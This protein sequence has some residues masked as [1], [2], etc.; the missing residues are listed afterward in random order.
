MPNIE[1]MK[2]QLATWGLIPQVWDLKDSGFSLVDA[3]YLV[4]EAHTRG[5]AFIA[6]QYS[7]AA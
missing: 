4:Y 7:E 3:I 6:A 5:R 1:R 2:D